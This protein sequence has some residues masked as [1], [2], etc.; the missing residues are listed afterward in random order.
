MQWFADL[1]IARKLLLG[2]GL[3]AFVAGLVG[4]VGTYQVRQVAA[5]DAH[6]YQ[7]LFLPTVLIGDLQSGFTV[8]RVHLRSAAL[9]TDPEKRDAALRKIDSVTLINDS[10]V[11]AYGYTLYNASD[12]ANFA[13]LRQLYDSTARNRVLQMRLLR[14]NKMD[15]ARLVILDP[16]SPAKQVDNLLKVMVSQNKTWS[17]EV[18]GANED[19]ARRATIMMVALVILGVLTAVTLG[20]LIA[21]QVAQPL[22]T[23]REA[24]DRLALGNLNLSLDT[25]RRDEVGQLSKSFSAMIDS[26][27]ALAEHATQI[28]AGVLDTPVTMRSPE[29]T[30]SAS[31]ERLRTTILAVTAEGR[32][33]AKAGAEGRLSARGDVKK[34][35]GAYRDLVGG[36]NDTLD[37]VISP[38]SE[39][40][41]V[42]ELWAK[43]DLRRR[44]EGNYRGDHARI[45]LAM[46]STA[47]ALDVALGDISGAVDQVSAA[48]SQI[49]A[50]SQSLAS[51]SSEQASSLE[52]VSASLQELASAT[53]SNAQDALQARSLADETTTNVAEGVKQMTELTEAMH[54]I[55]E[56]SLQ[57]AKI[58]RT[59]DEIAFQTNLLALNAAVEAARAGDAGRGFAVVADEVRTL[60]IRAAE[61][62]RQTTALIDDA[63]ARVEGGVRKNQEVLATLSAIEKRAVSVSSVVQSI[64][65]A[66]AEQSEGIRQITAA[67]SEMNTVTQSVAANAEESASAAEELASQ[68]A[69]MQSLVRAFALRGGSSSSDSAPSRGALSARR[70]S[71]HSDAD[72]HLA[73]F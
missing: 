66:S 31:F 2:F 19:L 26:Q 5:A 60:A 40:T 37:A 44:V 34:F 69:T 30:L 17:A 51:G 61:S 20:I 25:S 35:Q 72:E 18:S 53:A 64:A 52:E 63:S 10:L 41:T 14:E 50:G 56:S 16:A 15:S 38:I 73:I 46:N 1:R 28:S 42:L 68:A 45:K 21:R 3:V 8:A 54:A 7:D 6:L 23:V 67:V 48:G 12:S 32:D 43:R 27:R 24:A 65:T 11:V 39:A 29:D 9:E 70:F 71:T 57:T 58:V 49:A 36:M 33:L 4:A 59:I 47:D 55:R 22:A 62:A 13:R